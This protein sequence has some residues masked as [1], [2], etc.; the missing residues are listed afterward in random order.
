MSG[1]EELGRGGRLRSSAADELVRAAYAVESAHGPALARGLSLADLAH[2]VALVEGGDLRGDDAQA[3]LGGLLELHEIP[4][5]RFPWD[6]AAGDAFNARE[7]E[8]E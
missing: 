4:G 7:A 3:L 6:P 5:E 8:L 1:T 2:A